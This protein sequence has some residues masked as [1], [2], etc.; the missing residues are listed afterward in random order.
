MPDGLTFGSAPGAASQTDDGLDFADYIQP[1]SV[2]PDPIG[3]DW[4]GPPGP[5]GPAGGS[6]VLPI[7]STTVLGGVKVDGSTIAISGSGVISSA[8]MGG[9]SSWNTRTGAVVLTSADVTAALTFTPYNATNPAGYQTAAQVTTSLAPYA[10]LNAP[11]FTGDARAVTAAPGDSDTSIATT[12]FVA[13]ALSGASGGANVGTT[14]PAS[15]AVG[16]LWWDSN[17]GNLYVRY[18]DGT[19][20]QWVPATAQGPTT[21]LP[22]SFP[23][24]GRPAAGALVNVPM[25]I[26]VTVPATLAGAV[27]FSTTRTTASAVFAVNRITV[28]GVTTQLGT[29]TVTATSATSNTLAG[30]GGTLAAGDT[31]QIVAPGTQDATLADLGIT[32]LAA[33]V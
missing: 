5:P 4:R 13:A 14:P 2:P 27:T 7:A 9:V 21:S 24:A 29:V 22:I 16:A 19:S 23:F 32:V 17:G 15:P 10:P 20:T 6:Y 26:A 30:T 18:N 25:P 28:A 8:A 12:A 31:L 3:D 1:P 33:R 11:V